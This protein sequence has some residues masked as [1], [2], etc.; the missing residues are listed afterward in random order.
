[1]IV[2]PNCRNVN[3]EDTAFCSRCGA[4]LDPGPAALKARRATAE[5]PQ[6]EIPPPPQASKWRPV[7]VLGLMGAVVVAAGVYLLFRP[8]PCRGTNFTS[9]RFGY[10]LDVPQGWTAEPAVFG[11]TAT[12]DQFTPPRDTATVLVEAHDLSA[13][14][15]V[16]DWAGF[17]RQ[18]EQDAGLI[19]GPISDLSLDGNRAEQWDVSATSDGGVSYTMRDVVVVV[20]DVGWRVT[21]NGAE[22]AFAQQTTSFGGMLDSWRFR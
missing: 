8:D 21:L 12:L 4:S 18:K 1:M 9:T 5:R 22:G 16:T 20:D 7:M 10:C 15:T 11:G 6:I 2:C 17:V 13:G 19:P 3:E 14:A